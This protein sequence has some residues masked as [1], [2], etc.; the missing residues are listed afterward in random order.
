MNTAYL[1]LGS[2]L[3]DR[4]KMIQQA[5]VAISGRIGPVTRSSSIYQSEPWGFE[6]ENSFLNQVILIETVLS[7]EE[8]LD[9]I[10]GIEKELGRERILLKQD[11]YE[12]RL[13]DIDILFYNNEIIRG[14]RLNIPHPHIS[15]RMFTLI[16]L[17]ELN[18]GF[19][20]PLLNKSMEVLKSECTDQNYVV[21]F[22]S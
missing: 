12:S 16:P 3:Q 6:A 14:D 4:E 22:N 17:C 9:E 7:P 8:L 11:G 5:I 2:N 10:L 15:Q 13:I 19:I 1:L 20:H 18:G 21:I